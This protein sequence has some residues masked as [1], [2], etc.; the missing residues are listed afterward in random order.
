MA[1]ALAGE[2]WG[3]GVQLRSAGVAAAVGQPASPHARAVA[4]SHG[5]DLDAH[6][7]RGATDLGAAGTN[8]FVTMTGAQ[9]D[10]LL[11]QL[12]VPKSTVLTLAELAGTREDVG[13]PFGGGVEDYERCYEQL[14]RLID[15]STEEIRRRAE[16]I[17]DDLSA[18]RRESDPPH[19]H[20]EKGSSRE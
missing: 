19:R 15:A 6:R 3:P 14:A 16:E 17:T 13:D 11:E 2:H 8:L 5:L 7:A 18:P 10:V 1:E 4:A 20:P 12:S 9:R